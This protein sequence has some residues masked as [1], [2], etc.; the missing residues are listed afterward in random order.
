[1]QET[2]PTDEV[3]SKTVWPAVAV[4]LFVLASSALALGSTKW[5]LKN[6]H[7]WVSGKLRHIIVYGTGKIYLLGYGGLECIDNN[8]QAI[9]VEESLIL[10]YDCR[11]LFST[12]RTETFWPFLR[13]MT[14]LF[15]Y[16]FSG[17]GYVIRQ[18]AMPNNQRNS[19]NPLMKTIDAILNG[20]GKV[21]GF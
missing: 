10:G 5:T 12:V 21:F 7:S 20:I 2:D 9:R 6:I 16:Q 1:M 4:K 15:D 11:K 18:N 17:P 19:D 3:T 13:G 8:N 14:S